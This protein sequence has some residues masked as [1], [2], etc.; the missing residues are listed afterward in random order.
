MMVHSR[1]RQVIEISCISR[2]LVDECEY[3]ERFA[4]CDISFL[5]VRVEELDTWQRS[6]SCK[7]P[8]KGEYLR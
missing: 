4:E 5:A 6:N 3:R 8:G 7:P 1:T 2:H